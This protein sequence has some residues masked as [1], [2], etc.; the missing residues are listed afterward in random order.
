MPRKT[1]KYNEEE[2]DKILLYLASTAQ[3][4]RGLQNQK[5]FSDLKW[6]LLMAFTV[7][8]AYSE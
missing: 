8:S 7:L 2:E 6:F 4:L 5:H 1:M 3:K